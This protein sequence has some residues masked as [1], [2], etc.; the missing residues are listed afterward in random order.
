MLHVCL[1]WKITHFFGDE[2]IQGAAAITCLHLLFL[3]HIHGM[4]VLVCPSIIS[5]V[6][7]ITVFNKLGSKMSSVL[8]RLASKEVCGPEPCDPIS[9]AKVAGAPG[10][11]DEN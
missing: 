9:S 2:S 6:A 7:G 11:N 5:C 8:A 4:H 10:L 3:E 1:A